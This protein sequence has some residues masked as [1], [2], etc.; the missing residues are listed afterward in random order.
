VEQLHGEVA[1][2]AF[3]RP[4]NDMIAADG[5]H[6]HSVRWVFF[7]ILVARLAYSAHPEG[8]FLFTDAQKILDPDLRDSVHEWRDGQG[9][10]KEGDKLYL[11]GTDTLAGSVTTMDKSIRNFV[12]FTGCSIGDAIK[13]A[14]FNPAK[15][16]GIEHRKGTLRHGADADLVVLDRDGIS[17][18]V[19]V[20]GRQA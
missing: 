14:T 15:C 10:V 5:I 2:K 17:Q 3:V 11:A 19:W 20:R 7:L 18:N 6:L 4:L 8:C 12:R 9:F 1:D 16:V 13:C